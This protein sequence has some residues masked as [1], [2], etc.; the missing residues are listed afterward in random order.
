MSEANTTKTLK[1]HYLTA[2]YKAAIL[3]EYRNNIIDGKLVYAS[4]LAAQERLDELIIESAKSGMIATGGFIVR[5]DKVGDNE[6]Y[7]DIY[8]S[9]P[10]L[11][12]II[13]LQLWR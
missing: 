11:G 7:V 5:S 4:Y 1:L 2:I 10:A 12:N 6:Y 9:T 13:H 8:M 3:Y